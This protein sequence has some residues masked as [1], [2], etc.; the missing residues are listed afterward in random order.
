MS[1]TIA[2]V[3]DFHIARDPAF[4]LK[5]EHVRAN[6]AA[7]VEELVSTHDLDIVL[8]GGDV[9]HDGSPESYDFVAEH[10]ARVPVPVVA[11]P[12]NHDDAAR[13]AGLFGP[14][15]S[16][17]ID[18]LLA[19]ERAGLQV[20]NSQIPG[21]E[22][23]RLGEVTRA[24]I[25]DGHLAILLVHHDLVQPD[26]GG[27]PGMRSPAEELVKV[28]SLSPPVLVLTGHRHVSMDVSVGDVRIVGAPATSTQ[29]LFDDGV[30]HRAPDSA[31]AYRRLRIDGGRMTATE[32]RRLGRSG[33]D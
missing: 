12:G 33:T 28:L 9:S 17:L 13:L 27:R 7:V 10:F 32:V 18:R 24:P 26:A 19:R 1:L 2:H 8:I 14:D 11:A 16:D 6:L 3:S 5:G 30:P 15:H 25:S 22:D 29:F 23:G 31:P 4:R 20:L 21:H